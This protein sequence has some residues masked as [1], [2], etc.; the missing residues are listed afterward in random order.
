MTIKGAISPPHIGEC[1]VVVK[2]LLLTDIWQI[3]I[4]YAIVMIS[5]TVG[6]D[7]HEATL[8]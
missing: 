4:I 7:I 8:T 2:S 3:L 5:E 1:M 6:I